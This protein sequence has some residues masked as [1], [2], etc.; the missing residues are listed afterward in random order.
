MDDEESRNV[1]ITHAATYA[2]WIMVSLWQM[3]PAKISVSRAYDWRMAMR[4]WEIDMAEMV[5]ARWPFIQL[6]C[7]LLSE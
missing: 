2:H 6:Y 4:T 5:R 3:D 1:G 7:R